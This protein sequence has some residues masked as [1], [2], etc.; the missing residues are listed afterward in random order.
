MNELTLSQKRAYLAAIEKIVKEAGEQIL[1]QRGVEI[2]DTYDYKGHESSTID[3]FARE[4]IQT[5]IDHHLPDFEGVMRLELRPYKKSLIEVERHNPLVLIVDEIEGT[6]NT[7]RCLSASMEYRPQAIVSIALSVSESL[8]DL[9]GGAVYTL[10][11]GE[12]FSALR[13]TENEFLTFLNRKL[14]EPANI[15][16]T[17]GDSRNRVLVIGYSNSH[18]VRKGMV[19]QALYDKRFKVYD[20]CRAS[21]MDIINVLRNQTDAYI[22]LRHFWSTKNERGEEKE[23]M[24]QVYDIAG[25][26]PIA[27]GCGLKVSDA[28]GKSWQEYSLDDTIPLV[29]ARPAIHQSILDIIYPLVE[30]WQGGK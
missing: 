17:R 27:E 26:I 19:E 8:K 29:I 12:V 9:V 28:T 24:L 13:V 25:V 3:V 30:K 15:I 22:D 14:I 1:T 6:T 5:A 4:R 7:K 11:Q 21:G 23:A 18:R 16:Q 20:G 10:D 2:A